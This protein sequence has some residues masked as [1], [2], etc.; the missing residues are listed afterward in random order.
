ME[1]MQEDSLK[2]DPVG[3]RDQRKLFDRHHPIVASQRH[4]GVIVTPWCKLLY[5]SLPRGLCDPQ[6]A[7]QALIHSCLLPISTTCGMHGTWLLRY[8]FLS[9]HCWLRILMLSFSPFFTEQLTA[10]EVWPDHGSEH[11]KP[12]EQLPIVLQGKKGIWLKLLVERAELVPV[13][14]EGGCR[15]RQR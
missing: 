6:I 2:S 12:P 5:N 13:A 3:I 11:K 14:V 15:E 4:R 10:F 7:L 9:F 1:Q 8:A